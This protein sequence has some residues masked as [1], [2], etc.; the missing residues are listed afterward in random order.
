MTQFAVRTTTMREQRS[1]NLSSTHP[2]ADP[3]TRLS[4]H[5]CLTRVNTGAP[6]NWATERG[7]QEQ[8]RGKAA[9]GIKPAAA[10][11]D[12]STTTERGS[13]FSSLALPIGRRRLA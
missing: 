2:V 4:R 9:G 1:V 10:N 13:G 11:R 6:T 5:G 3:Q 7:V 12:G 8:L